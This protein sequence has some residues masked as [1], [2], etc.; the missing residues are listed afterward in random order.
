MGNIIASIIQFIGVALCV[1]SAIATGPSLAAVL[2]LVAAV[3]ALP[4]KKV[5]NFLKKKLKIKSGAAIFLSM[6]L[7]IVAILV[8]PNDATKTPDNQDTDIPISE[9]ETV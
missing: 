9:E 8:I 4:S 6:L 5:K 1:I 3:L 7:F 2:F